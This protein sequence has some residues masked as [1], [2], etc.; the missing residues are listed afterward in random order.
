MALPPNWRVALS[1]YKLRDQVD[2]RWPGRG[3]QSDGLVADP[4][5][6]PDSDHY[7]HRVAALGE[8]PVVTAIDIT[9]DPARGVDTVR[10]ARALGASLDPR[11]KYIVAHRRIMSTHPVTVRG[12][13]YP[14]WVWRPYEEDDPHESHMHLSVVDGA[15]ADNIQPWSITPGRQHPMFMAKRTTTA[16]V[17]LS[18]GAGR[19]GP[20]SPVLMNTLISQGMPYYQVD[21]G[22]F[23]ALTIGCAVQVDP[24]AVE[25]AVDDVM[26]RVGFTVRPRI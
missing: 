1:L 7:P 21:P 17:Y 14:A 23:D 20:I 22:D 15:I 26:G 13:T 11:I 6:T 18:N 3:K 19:F 24:A 8:R 16:D 4:R 5:H 12:H 2:L 9:H 25:N 10:L